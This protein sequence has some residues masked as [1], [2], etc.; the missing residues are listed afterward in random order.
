MCHSAHVEIKDHLGYWFSIFTLW[1][2]GSLLG[3]LTPPPI[4]PKEC[5]VKDMFHPV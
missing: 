1:E 4:W 2:N 5:Q 3:L